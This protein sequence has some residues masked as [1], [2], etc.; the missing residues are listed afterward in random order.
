M[1]LLL[2]KRLLFTPPTPIVAQ[3]KLQTAGAAT[4]NF[5][6]GT[7]PSKGSLLL[8]ALSNN[9]TPEAITSGS[10]APSG[11]T[12]LDNLGIGSG[13]APQLNTGYL[14]ADGSTNSFT[15]TY[16]AGS[17]MNVYGFEMPRWT[18]VVSGGNNFSTGSN[19]IVTNALNHT[20]EINSLTFAFQA[21]ANTFSGLSVSTGVAG[22][23]ITLSNT[24][25][26]AAEKYMTAAETNV[27]PTWTWVTNR[28][29]RSASVKVRV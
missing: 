14:V 1:I 12:V 28:Q 23:T 5:S 13:N 15:F 25:S 26:G 10:G 16:S 3:R 8:F 21:T 20:Y 4:L 29:A 2:K 11:W 7:V 27:G 17:A 6:F 18:S 24:R 22:Y 9:N 19:N